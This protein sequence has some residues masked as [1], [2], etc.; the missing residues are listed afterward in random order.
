MNTRLKI[1]KRAV[2]C[3]PCGGKGKIKI[4]EGKGAIMTCPYCRGL[5]IVMEETN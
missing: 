1:A 3:S 2:R 4:Y 5:G